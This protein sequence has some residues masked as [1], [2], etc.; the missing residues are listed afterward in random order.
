VRA[1]QPLVGGLAELG[2]HANPILRSSGIEPSVLDDPDATVRA[3]LVAAFWEHAL[4]RT[5]DDMLGLHLAESAPIQT[6][7]VHAYALLSSPSLR[8][9]YRRAS[10]YQRLIHEST[11]LEFHEEAD[12]G[13]LVHHLPGGRPVSRQPAEFLAA[14]WVRLGRRVVQRDWAPEAVY[15]GH[16]PGEDRGEYDRVFA[17]P[18]HF[19]AGRTALAVG[20]DVLDAPAASA[21]A[22]LTDILDRH[23][24]SILA[25]RPPRETLADRVRAHLSER[26]QTGELRAASVARALAMSERTLRRGLSAEGTSFRDLL[27]GLRLEQAVELLAS[28]RCSIAEVAYLLGFSEVS[29]FHRAF[30]RWTGRTP[31]DVRTAGSA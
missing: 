21:D 15:F 7:D 11:R 5:G 4:D 13:T 6:F 14:V 20:N 28:R 3:G 26:L 19:G 24:A 8:E 25:A 9:A 18:V 16:S 30:K 27:D 10:R 23:V 2:I 17:A 12:R 22:R 1:L 31:A 29:A